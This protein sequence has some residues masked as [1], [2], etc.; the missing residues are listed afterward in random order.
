MTTGAP[1][2]ISDITDKVRWSD[3]VYGLGSREA[4]MLTFARKNQGTLKPGKQPTTYTKTVLSKVDWKTDFIVQ[5]IPIST[6]EPRQPELVGKLV[7]M[8]SI[9]PVEGPSRSFVDPDKEV[10]WDIDRWPDAVM[11]REVFWFVM[12]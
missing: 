12:T 6:P 9:Y 4:P 3:Q 2:K 10:A 1:L 11:M 5:Y 7:S 8:V